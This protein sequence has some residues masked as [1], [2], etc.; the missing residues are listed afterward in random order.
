M[1]RRTGATSSHSRGRDRTF[2]LVQ[3]RVQNN[4]LQSISGAGGHH[5][6]LAVQSRYILVLHDGQGS[7]RGCP[8]LLACA[9]SRHAPATT[10]AKQRQLRGAGSLSSWLLPSKRAILCRIS[11]WK[12]GQPEKKRPIAT[13]IRFRQQNKQASGLL[14]LDKSPVGPMPCPLLTEAPLNTLDSLGPPEREENITNEKTKL[15]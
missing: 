8:V 5:E 11:L 13:E 6:H 9:Q 10:C 1:A 3:S 4:T 15:Y 12:T 14:M 2:V 7:C